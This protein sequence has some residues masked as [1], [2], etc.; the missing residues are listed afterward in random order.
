[1]NELAK[2]RSR[3]GLKIN[4]DKTKVLSND[5]VTHRQLCIPKLKNCLAEKD[6]KGEV[7]RRIRCGWKVFN[8][9]KA[10]LKGDVP[11]TLEWKIFNQCLLPAICLLHVKPGL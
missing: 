7:T 2:E 9:H 3:R 4:T 8:D 1:M 6:M 5:H 11:I 10:L